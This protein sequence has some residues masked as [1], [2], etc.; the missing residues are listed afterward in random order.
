MCAC[1]CVCVHGSSLLSPSCLVVMW[2]VVWRSYYS[3]KVMYDSCFF[4]FIQFL[5]HLHSLSG[6]YI[7]HTVH[8]IISPI[9]RYAFVSLVSIVCVFTFNPEYLW[10]YHQQNFYC[11]LT[12]VFYWHQAIMQTTALRWSWCL[13][14]AWVGMSCQ[15]MLH[16]LMFITWEAEIKN[17]TATTITTTAI[18]CNAIAACDSC[19]YDQYWL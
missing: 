7:I 16:L 9:M 6:Y 1:V 2:F 14:W 13:L 11:A 18:T 12:R 10:V 17:A 8:F 5:Y 19:V 3:P 15:H 4:L